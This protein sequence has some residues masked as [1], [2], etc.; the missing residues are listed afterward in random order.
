MVPGSELAVQAGYCHLGIETLQL[1][2]VGDVHLPVQMLKTD[3]PCGLGTYQGFHRADLSGACFSGLSPWWL[4]PMSKHFKNHMSGDL[5]HETLSQW[6]QDTT[7]L[8]SWPQFFA[9]SLQGLGLFCHA[10]SWAGPLIGTIALSFSL[11][12]THYFEGDTELLTP[13]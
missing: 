7:I 6:S 12:L 10:L 9:F 5:R 11:S 3:F 1:V 13:P 2:A 8:K 4:Q